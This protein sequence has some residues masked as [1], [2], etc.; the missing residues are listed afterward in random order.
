MWHT[1]GRSA[2]PGREPPKTQEDGDGSPPTRFQ[3][4]LAGTGP[5]TPAC[6]GRGGGGLRGGRF[7]DRRRARRR[8]G[9]PALGQPGRAVR[10]P[11]LYPSRPPGRPVVGAGQAVQMC[12]VRPDAAA[13]RCRGHRVPHP[14]RRRG[15]SPPHSRGDH[16]SGDVPGTHDLRGAGG[17]GRHGPRRTA[18]PRP[19][20]VG[21][22]ARRQRPR[23]HRDRMGPPKARC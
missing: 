14:G 9:R 1:A 12:G 19:R 20:G 17:A 23:R 13:A 4:D 6:A 22:T 10:Q 3:R 16:G 15:S 7:R 21:R 18:A 8:I 5:C 11:L 2:G